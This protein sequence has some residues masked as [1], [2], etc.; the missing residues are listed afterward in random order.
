MLV[1]E[2]LKYAWVTQLK[3]VSSRKIEINA[4]LSVHVLV[5]IYMS[6]SLRIQYIFMVVCVQLQLLYYVLCIMYVLR[7]TYL[8]LILITWVTSVRFLSRV[9]DNRTYLVVHCLSHPLTRTSITSTVWW[10]YVRPTGRA[11]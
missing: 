11:K 6:C 5:C 1:T 8:L 4:T 7:I 9:G 2:I 10:V 3:K